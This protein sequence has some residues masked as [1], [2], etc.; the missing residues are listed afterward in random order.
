[1]YSKDPKSGEIRPIWGKLIPYGEVWRTGADEATTLITEK[2]IVLGGVTVPAGSY[3]LYTLPAADGSAKL[4]VNKEL[5][6]WG[7][8]Y[9]PA[10]DLARIDLTRTTLPAPVD[11]FTI[12]LTKGPSGSGVI[13]MA[14]ENTQYSVSYTVAK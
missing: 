1:V 6:Q 3:T 2:S 7:T 11:Q 13:A 8:V 4:I 10:Q 9:D 5:G 14:W 12:T